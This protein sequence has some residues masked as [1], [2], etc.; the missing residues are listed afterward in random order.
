MCLLIAME[1]TMYKVSPDE[2]FKMYR[3]CELYMTQ[4]KCGMTRAW[5]ATLIRFG[6]YQRAEQ[7]AQ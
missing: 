1:I 6:Y 2:L 3:Y 4:H 5:K 7:I